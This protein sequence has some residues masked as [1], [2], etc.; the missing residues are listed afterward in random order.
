LGHV[1]REDRTVL[2]SSWPLAPLPQRS[3]LLQFYTSSHWESTISLP[4]I[5]TLLRPGPLVKSPQRMSLL[6]TARCIAVASSSAPGRASGANSVESELSC[7]R[8]VR[9]RKCRNAIN[10]VW[11]LTGLADR[12]DER[13]RS[14]RHPRSPGT[15]HAT[16]LAMLVFSRCL[17][18]SCFSSA[19]TLGCFSRRS[20]LSKSSK[21][22]IYHASHIPSHTTNFLRL[23]PCLRKR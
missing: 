12:E 14:C 5:S 22:D 20:H 6:Y 11:S 21:C 19:S 13:E 8:S 16:S 4:C 17:F 15:R 23:G 18:F 10:V 3:S 2:S 7:L 1:I 9:R